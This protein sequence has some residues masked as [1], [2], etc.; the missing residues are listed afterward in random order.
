MRTT[1]QALAATLSDATLWHSNRL[2]AES[3]YFDRLLDRE[4]D[5]T[6]VDLD[7]GTYGY[8][9]ECEQNVH[10]VKRDFGYGPNEYWGSRGVHRLEREVCPTCEGDLS[11]PLEDD[12]A[13]EP[14]A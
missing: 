5:Y 3:S 8:C 7:E 9:P 12:E 1:Q 6:D 11:K 14:E 13:F 10:S 2:R 4:P